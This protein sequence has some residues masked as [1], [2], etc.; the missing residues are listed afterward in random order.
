MASTTSVNQRQATLQI[1]TKSGISSILAERALALYDRHYDILAD[2]YDLPTIREILFRISV[3]DSIKECQP[4]YESEKDVMD[5]LNSMGFSVRI[6]KIAMDKYREF[7]SEKLPSSPITKLS[8]HLETV[9]KLALLSRN[10]NYNEAPL[11]NS[12]SIQLQ[13][14]GQH[15]REQRVHSQQRCSKSLERLP[16]DLEPRTIPISR[17]SSRASS[18]CS[19]S[20]ISL[21]LDTATRSRSNGILNTA[22]THNEEVVEEYPNTNHCGYLWK[23]SSKFESKW[24]K[25]W[26]VLND[27]ELQYFKD[28]LR[29]EEYFKD[30]QTRYADHSLRKGYIGPISMCEVAK[31]NLSKH[32]FVISITTP[33]QRTYL[34]K[35]TNATEYKQWVHVLT[36]HYNIGSDRLWAYSQ[37]SEPLKKKSSSS[38]SLKS[39]SSTFSSSHSLSTYSAWTS[40]ERLPSLSDGVSRSVS[41]SG[42]LSQLSLS[43]GLKSM[44]L[45]ISE[46]HQ[47]VTRILEDNP[48]CADCG[49]G[50]PEWVSINIGVILCSKCCDVH[51]SLGPDISNVHSLKMETLEVST[52]TL[53]YIVDLGGNEELN[54]RLLEYTL[55][56]WNKINHQT[57][58]EKRRCDFIEQKYL[59]KGYLSHNENRSVDIRSVDAYLLHSVRRNDLFGILFAVLNGAKI[60]RQFENCNMSA[61]QTAILGMFHVHFIV[62]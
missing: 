13:Q 53:Q 34:L 21:S 58:T 40:E 45:E 36:S 62:F 35:A 37:R 28:S 43:N 20:Q 8:Y 18:S 56:P 60:D 39:L 7:V 3:K 49:S 31:V 2:G 59:L 17:R 25:R 47:L 46:R 32:Q 4:I 55:S 33:M 1:L 48:Q 24:Q 26:F 10:T 30:E 41:G 27:G 44:S 16:P 11:P 50:Q 61:L 29:A 54:R 15:Q 51:R 42:G 12:P 57:V 5:I 23:R 6:C 19:E 22:N 52:K 9:A 38:S 14:Q